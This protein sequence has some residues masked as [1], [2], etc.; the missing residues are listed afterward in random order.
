MCV[1]E[2][3]LPSGAQGRQ[4]EGLRAPERRLNTSEKRLEEERE[5]GKEEEGG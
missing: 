1:L 4:E 5:P 2:R 3:K